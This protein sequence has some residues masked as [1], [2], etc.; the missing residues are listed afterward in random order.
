MPLITQGKANVKYLL[1]VGLVAAVAGGIIFV[2]WNTYQ[3]EII[4]S[5]NF[6]EIKKSANNIKSQ[7]TGWKTY[8][9]NIFGF[10]FKYP[11]D[12][13]IT[14]DALP[15]VLSK[16]AGPNDK[17]EITNNSAPEKP[18]ISIWVNPEG[19]G[20]FPS[21]ILYTLSSTS[22]EG[23]K[24]VK[25]EVVKNQ[26]GLVYITNTLPLGQTFGGNTYWLHFSFKEGGKDY[27]PVFNQI[28]STFNFIG[29]SKSEGAKNGLTIEEIV[30]LN[31]RDFNLGE[32]DIKQIETKGIDSKIVLIKKKTKEEKVLIGSTVE[33][34]D[35]INKNI[36][37]RMTDVMAEYSVL[38]LKGF[39]REEG[40]IYFMISYEYSG[41]LF[42]LNINSLKIREIKE[43][44][45]Y[46]TTVFSPDGD[47]AVSLG[48][49][50]AAILYLICFNNDTKTAAINLKDGETFEERIRE[51]D[52]SFYVKWLDGKNIEYKVYKNEAKNYGDINTFIETRTIALPDCK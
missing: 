33:L 17:L 35:Y 21:D 1:I 6:N 22:D 48:E 24:V 9:N 52:A 28:I 45:W 8:S 38:S 30:L 15:K 5:D 41:P 32:W 23:I 13:E 29:T 25:R 31:G 49:Y 40:E 20:P 42:A 7:T 12:W 10:S 43:F 26:D 51:L 44:K 3:K 36:G 4:I 14:S 50:P 47:R 46:G 34:R 39:S 16:T 11:Q 27:E 2:A 18:V 19:F 37:L